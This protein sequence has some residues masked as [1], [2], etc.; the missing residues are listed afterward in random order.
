MTRTEF[1][2]HLTRLESAFCRNRMSQPS[3]DVYFEKLGHFKDEDLG[4]AVEKII[5][6]NDRFPAI[7]VIR[8]ATDAAT[9]P[10]YDTE[11]SIMAA[12]HNNG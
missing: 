8:K 9:P 2:K 10:I 6:D 5:D 7:S 4:R 1:A 3:F 12:R 11:E